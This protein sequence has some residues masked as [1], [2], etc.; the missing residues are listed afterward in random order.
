MRLR[1]RA[2]AVLHRLGLAL[3]AVIA[4]Y[5]VGR[6]VVEVIILDPTRPD[7]YQRDWGGPHYLGVMAVHAGPGLL[8]LIV[9][10]LWVRRATRQ[11]RLPGSSE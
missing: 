8:V 6:A 1:A 3:V 4:V 10:V 2:A 5:L 7:S 9:A 11:G